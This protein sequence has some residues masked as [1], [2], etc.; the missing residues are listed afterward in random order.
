MR[1][2][3]GCGLVLA[4]SCGSTVISAK[5]LS[6]SC[7]V[8]SDCIAVYLGDACASCGCANAAISKSSQSAYDQEDADARQACWPRRTPS[9]GCIATAAA[10]SNGTCVQTSP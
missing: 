10:C 9:C 6:T 5:G 1:R 7:S 2:L 3:V 8:D 4:M